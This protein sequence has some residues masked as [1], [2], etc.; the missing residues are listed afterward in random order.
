MLILPPNHAAEIRVARG[1]SQRE[2]WMLSGVGAVV[3]ALIV[4]LVIALS[5]GDPTSA[6]GCVEVNLPYSTGGANL[7]SCGARARAMC[8]EV[9]QPGAFTGAAASALAT[10]CR[11]A[12]VPVGAGA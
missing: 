2:R 12:H 6:N 4:V 5:T 7:H 9:G 10:Q 8:G 1:F 11:K 3:A